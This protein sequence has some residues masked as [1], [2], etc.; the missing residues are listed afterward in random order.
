[1]NASHAQ[2]GP[3]AGGHPPS[4]EQI[5]LLKEAGIR[6]QFTSDPGYAIGTYV[7]G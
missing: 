4:P 3:G 5:A 6:K 7:M 2:H 1:M